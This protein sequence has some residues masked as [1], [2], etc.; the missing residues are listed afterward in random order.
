MPTGR[1]LGDLV[2]RRVLI[3]AAHMH[4]PFDGLTPAVEG[5]AAV[6]PRDRQDAEIEAGGIAAIDLDLA[7]ASGLAL[8]ERREVHE[9]KAHRAF[10]LVGVGPGEKDGRAMGV[11]AP[12]GL[13]YA[14]SR[15]IGEKR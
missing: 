13:G 12:D 10:H 4:G 7:L 14:M 1:P 2:E 8:Q 5:E 6:G 11:D 3:E 15:R 9:G